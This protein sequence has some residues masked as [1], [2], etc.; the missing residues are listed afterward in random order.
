MELDNFLTLNMPFG[1]PSDVELSSASYIYNF[2]TPQYLKKQPAWKPF[3]YKGKQQIHFSILEF[4]RC[5]QSDQAGNICHFE[6]FGQVMVKADLE[7]ALNTVSISVSSSDPAR[8]LLLDSLVIH[9]CVEVHCDPS[10]PASSLLRRLRFSPPLHEFILFH[11]CSPE[12][13]Q[14]PVQGVFKMLGENPVELLVQLKLNEYMKNNFEFFDVII[15]FFNRGPVK[16]IDF[17]INCGAPKLSEDKHT[18]KWSIGAKFPKDLEAVITA[19]LEFYDKPILRNSDPFC[20]DRNC[21]AQ[22]NFKQNN[23]NLSGCV[24]DPKNVTLS[25]MSKA[26]IIIDR[27]IQSAEYRI[28]NMYGDLPFPVNISNKCKK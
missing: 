13:K 12:P 28:W 11:Y 8:P 25:Q 20:V 27:N 17:N 24:I 1:T 10:S 4:V 6:I 7:G 5:M 19:K 26:K 21:Y 14:P 16:S 15:A 9:P 2:Q 3:D 18:L 23:T 22:I